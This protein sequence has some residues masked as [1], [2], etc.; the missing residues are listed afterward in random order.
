MAKEKTIRTRYAPSPTGFLHIGGARTALFNYVFAKK[1]HGKF[2]LRIEDTDEVRN[3]EGG[4]ISLDSDL[5]FLGIFPDESFFNPGSKGP[6]LQSQKT[7]RYL[8]ICEELLNQGKAY[9]C[10]C[11]EKELEEAKNSAIANNSPPFYS[12]KCRN[13]TEEEIQAKLDDD[14][15]YTVRLKVD[16]KKEYKWKDLVRGEIVFQ[17][18]SL[19]DYVIMRSNKVPT[20]NFAVVVDDHDMEINY[21]LRGEEHISNTPFQLATYYALGWED[22]IPQF[23]HLSI[24]VDDD[25][26]KLS[27]RSANEFHFISGLDKKGYPPEAIFNFLALLGWS[28]GE[29][30]IFSVDEIIKAFNVESLSPSPAFYDVKKLNWISRKYFQNMSPSHYLNFVKY[31]FTVDLGEFNSKKELFALANKKNIDCAAQLNEMATDFYAERS[32]SSEN[33]DFLKNHF[34]LLNLA[35]DYFPMK[36]EAWD[37]TTIRNYLKQLM[38]ISGLKGKDFFRPL[39][40]AFSLLE[41]GFELVNVMECL[42]REVLSRNLDS[43]LSLIRGE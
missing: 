27:K 33:I 5:K 32:L 42:G 34:Q 15:P 37:S 12:R 23:G 28:N 9:R 38:Q 18:H 16:L 36:S 6:Y 2:I 13:L 24:I 21:V 19:Q 41:E 8:E 7:E 30:E 35:K 39:R 4:H 40:L 1:H 29:E 14:I 22:S 26:K 17:E 10:F 11:S 25:K 20:Y 43:S 3:I 31:H